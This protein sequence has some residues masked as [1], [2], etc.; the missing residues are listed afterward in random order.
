ME[1]KS[2]SCFKKH[3]DL[4]IQIFCRES[5][6]SHLVG[7]EIIQKVQSFM[8]EGYCGVVGQMWLYCSAKQPNMRV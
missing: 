2:C 1:P 5:N 7:G 6:T 8:A 3:S 4:Q